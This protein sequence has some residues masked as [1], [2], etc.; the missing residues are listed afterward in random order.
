MIHNNLIILITFFAALI[1]VYLLIWLVLKTPLINFFRDKPGIRKVHQRVIPRV[2]GIAILLGFQ[3]FIIIWHF[4]IPSL[5]PLPP[6]LL[7]ALTFAAF[8]IMF[9]GLVD[10]MVVFHIHNKAKFILE[11]LIAVEIVFLNGIR[12]DEVHLLG[13][14]F[15]LGWMGIPIT[16]LWIVGVTNAINIIDGVDGLAGSI[17]AVIFTTIAI[18]TGFSGDGSVFL[19]C[20]IMAGFLSGFLLH[21]FS[22]ARVFLGDTGSLFLGVIIGVLSIYLISNEKGSYPILIAPLIVGLPLLDVFVAMSRRFIKKVIEGTPWMKAFGAMSIADNEHMHHRLIYRGLSHTETVTILVIF[23]AII[24][25]S[26][27]MVKFTSTTQNVIMLLYVLVLSVWFLYK[28][29]F[30]ERF[31]FLFIK[32]PIGSDIKKIA[33]A[34]INCGDVLKYSLQKYKQEAFNFTFLSTD[35]ILAD[36]R[37]YAAV[38]IEQEPDTKLEKTVALASAIFMQNA[39]P[40]VV[41]SDHEQLPVNL[42]FPEAEQGTYLL[43]KKPIYIPVLLRELVR[44]FRLSRSWS[45]EKVT[46]D[47]RQFFLQAV[48]NEDI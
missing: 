45:M 41:I 48:I 6:V 27:I 12:L 14:D 22:P 15:S 16:V 3:V 7:S 5:H 26:A 32:N 43:M 33:V 46:E 9:V 18:S 4:F 30:F 21:N 39:C 36:P 8:S 13:W 40:V 1:F 37:N 47:T 42:Q 35:D 25:M 19:L 34:V 20:I 44:I 29:H 11:V 31:Q 10:D 38:I 23:H 17:V 24:C 2:G 28:L